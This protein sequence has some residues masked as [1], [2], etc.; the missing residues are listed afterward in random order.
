LRVVD[1]FVP[2]E[3]DH[4]V[5]EVSQLVF[6]QLLP[7]QGIWVVDVLDAAVK[8]TDYATLPP[9]KIHPRNEGS[10]VENL[11]LQLWRRQTLLDEHDPGKR[12]AGT[13]APPIGE[14]NNTRGATLAPWGEV[15]EKPQELS[16][17]DSALRECAV[18]DD[19]RLLEWLPICTIEHSSCGSGHRKGA[20][21]CDFVWGERVLVNPQLP[22][23]AWR[24]FWARG[25]HEPSGWNLKREAVHHRCADVADRGARVECE[26]ARC[27]EHAME[28]QRIGGSGSE[29]L[30]RCIDAAAEGYPTPGPDPGPDLVVGVASCQ[31]LSGS[32]YVALGGGN[33]PQVRQHA[34]SVPQAHP[35]GAVVHRVGV[36][37]PVFNAGAP[38]CPVLRREPG[39]LALGTS[40]GQDAGWWRLGGQW[41]DEHRNEPAR[42]TT[43]H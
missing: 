42:R 29:G 23:T 5:A 10:S 43:A 28:F 35:R 22:I 15:G 2:R 41:W 21:C 19:N 6:A 8:L 20:E 38:P 37:L 33:R 7:P 32:E 25:V 31:R 12:F 34:L 17:C 1:D 39:G 16:V 9:K 40:G 36:Q 26:D 18:G 30:A 24:A 13:F 27:G 4:L 11:D 14:L 3:A